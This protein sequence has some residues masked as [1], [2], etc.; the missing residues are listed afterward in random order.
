M[1]MTFVCPEKNDIFQTK[2]FHIFNNNG[3]QIDANGNKSLDA[4]IK[5]DNP[6]PLCGTYHEY[7]ANELMCPFSG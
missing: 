1:E 4:R 5:L 6:C 7:H 3:I 2:H